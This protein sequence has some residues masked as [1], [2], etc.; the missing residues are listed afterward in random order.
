ML[1]GLYGDLP[2]P[3]ARRAAG[4]EKDI[5]RACIDWVNTIPGCKLW[6]Q[7]RGA[8]LNIY[9]RK[10][11]TEGRSY[12]KFG[13]PGATD[14]T[15]LANGIRLEIEIKTPGKTPDADQL[16]YMAMVRDADGIAFWCDSLSS[17]VT[18]LRQAFIARGWVWR[19][20]WE[21]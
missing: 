17:C 5:Q 18:Q 4:P 16:R 19:D 13:E 12:V 21:V 20:W 7:N 8:K 3:K 15:G 10:D 9:R 14:T 11:G 1:R 6:R 2:I